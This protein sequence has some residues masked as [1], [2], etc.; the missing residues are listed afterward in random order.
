VDR[1]GTLK[2]K[3]VVLTVADLQRMY[4]D[5]RERTTRAIGG[6]SEGQLVGTVESSVNPIVWAVGHCGR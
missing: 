2:E 5:V 3:H 1:Y 4:A 6:L